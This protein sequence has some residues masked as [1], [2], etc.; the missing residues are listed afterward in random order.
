MSS[1]GFSSFFF[2]VPDIRLG[3]SSPARIKH[4]SEKSRP[5]MLS[6]SQKSRPEMLITGDACYWGSTV[7]ASAWVT[8]AFRDRRCLNTESVFK[9]LNLSP[10][11]VRKLVRG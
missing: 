9:H 8:S 7:A 10:F 6:F 11:Q 1:T 5:E 3:I 4:L 2:D